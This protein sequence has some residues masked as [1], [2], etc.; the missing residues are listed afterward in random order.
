LLQ[1]YVQQMTSAAEDLGTYGDRL[2]GFVRR[3]QPKLPWL[4]DVARFDQMRYDLFHRQAP[5]SPAGLFEQR[6]S[7]GAAELW[8]SR[9]TL[10]TESRGLTFTAMPRP[11][12]KMQYAI[13]YR[14]AYAVRQAL[15]TP[16]QFNF[17]QALRRPTRLT[18][19][20]KAAERQK[21]L[22]PH[23]IRQLFSILGIGGVLV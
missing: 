10:F 4:S 3:Y 5:A 22:S 15:L 2:P 21:A 20:L 7:L 8:Q 6:V 19:L 9:Y 11:V 13:I 12:R 16:A 1:A 18:P 17:V 23:E 14:D